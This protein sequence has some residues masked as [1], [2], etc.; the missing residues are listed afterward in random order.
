MV[1]PEGRRKG[2]Q[3]LDHT[4]P[5]APSH[6]TSCDGRFVSKFFQPVEPELFV[7]QPQAV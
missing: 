5:E 4:V 6:Q 3:S 2:G 1:E 7:T